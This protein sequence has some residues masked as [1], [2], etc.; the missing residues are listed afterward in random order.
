[1]GIFLVALLIILGVIL[2]IYIIYYVNTLPERR[3]NKEKLR[4]QILLYEE[5]CEAEKA[6]QYARI[7]GTITRENINKIAKYK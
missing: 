5:R 3:K 1:M 2:I 4:R 6:K 7:A